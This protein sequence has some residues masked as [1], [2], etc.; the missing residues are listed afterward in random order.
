M[1]ITTLDSKINN[2]FTHKYNAAAPAEKQQLNK[3][4]DL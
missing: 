1:L 2:I 3:V 4:N